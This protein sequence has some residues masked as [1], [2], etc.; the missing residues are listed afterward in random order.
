M[1]RRPPP[2]WPEWPGVRAVLRQ[3][4]RFRRDGRKA[5]SSPTCAR[6]PPPP[7]PACSAGDVLVEFDG[8]SIQNLYDFTYALQLRKAGRH[9]GGQGVAGGAPIDAKVTLADRK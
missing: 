3:R 7:A 6:A 4:A 8:K 2:G 9:G 1:K 5:S